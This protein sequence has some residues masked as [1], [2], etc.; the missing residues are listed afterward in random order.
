M[1]V[2]WAQ[3]WASML[4]L[5]SLS[6]YRFPQVLPSGCVLGP[7]H[8]RPNLIW[9]SIMSLYN[10]ILVHFTFVSTVWERKGK[11]WRQRQSGCPL[12]TFKLKRAGQRTLCG[13]A[14]WPA[15]RSGDRPRP[16]TKEWREKQE[17]HLWFCFWIWGQAGGPLQWNC[18]T[19]R[20][21]C[22]GGIQ[23]YGQSSSSQ[24]Y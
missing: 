6:V 12:S 14:S 23:W 9:A 15:P 8:S 20:G 1:A 24:L 4:E 5:S 22:V 7:V 19:H 16:Q 17:L 21:L 3:G 10:S 2:S 13:G 18:T 11:Q